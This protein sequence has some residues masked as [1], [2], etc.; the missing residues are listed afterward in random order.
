M[1]DTLNSNSDDEIDLRELFVTLWAYK[2]LITCA[3]ALGI[4]F[5]GYYALNAEKEFTS[6]AIFKIDQS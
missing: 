2:F 5:G 3:C 4:V 6:A 1:Q